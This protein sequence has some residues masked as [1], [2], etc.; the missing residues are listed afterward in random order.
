[1]STEIPHD[2]SF[3]HAFGHFRASLRWETLARFEVD[4]RAGDLQHPRAPREPSA[5]V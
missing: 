4:R 3:R 5:E 2:S 1:V